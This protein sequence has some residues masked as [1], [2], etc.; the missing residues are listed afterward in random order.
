[1]IQKT[2]KE[3]KHNLNLISHEK[4][5]EKNVDAKTH[6]FGFWAINDSSSCWLQHFFNMVSL[7]LH[8]TFN[9]ASMVLYMP[10]MKEPHIF[11]EYLWLVLDSKCHLNGIFVR[12]V[13]I[14]IARKQLNFTCV[15][16]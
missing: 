1:M 4:L 14:T 11:H 3:K 5:L 9:I 16:T 13:M 8:E 10:F 12:L 15:N 2:Q 7:G 6:H